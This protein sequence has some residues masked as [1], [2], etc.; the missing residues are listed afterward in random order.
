MDFQTAHQIASDILNDNF[1][2]L[3][4]DPGMCV[5]AL[6]TLEADGVENFD[7][8]IHAVYDKVPGLSNYDDRGNW[9]GSVANENGW[10]A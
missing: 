10:T 7:E 3:D 2:L 5:R 9:I 6:H 8:L 4:R 1:G